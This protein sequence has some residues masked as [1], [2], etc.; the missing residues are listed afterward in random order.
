[1]GTRVF[2]ILWPQ[3]ILQYLKNNFILLITSFTLLLWWIITLPFFIYSYWSLFPLTEIKIN[4]IL[5]ISI[6][7]TWIAFLCR[8]LAAKYFSAILLAFLTNIIWVTTIIV[9]YYVFNE[10]REITYKLVIWAL[11]IILWSIYINVVSYE[12]NKPLTK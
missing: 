3:S 10:V 7:S 12:K 4:L 2:T 11:L 1:M 8:F 5:L 9:E 6:W